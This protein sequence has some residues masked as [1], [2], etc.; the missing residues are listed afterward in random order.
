MH[1]ESLAEHWSDRTKLAIART[2]PVPFAGAVAAVVG[3]THPPFPIERRWLRDETGPFGRGD[4]APARAHGTLG[5]ET[6][7]RRAV[8]VEVELAPWATSVTELVLRPVARAPHRWSGRRRRSWY[9]SA[10]AAADALRR[11]ILDAQ[12]SV[13]RPTGAYASDDS[14]VVTFAGDGNRLAG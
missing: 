13:S 11:Q 7:R 9:A 8:P 4:L 12:P 10:H 2:M 3:L 5:L 6:A 14:F 1:D